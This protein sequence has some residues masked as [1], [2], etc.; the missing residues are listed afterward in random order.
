MGLKA[1]LQKYFKGDPILW[2][3]IAVLAAIS[4][5][6]V[7]SSTG[8]LA[9]KYQGGNTYYYMFK[10]FVFL[11]VGIASYLGYSSNRL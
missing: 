9:Y 4:L 5:L 3:V 11:M 10:H 2:G 7:Y 6:A 8:S 1:A